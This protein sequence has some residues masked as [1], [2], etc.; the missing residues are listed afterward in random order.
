M[1]RSTLAGAAIGALALTACQTIGGSSQP[2]A[3]LT[4]DNNAVLAANLV[5]I[6]DLAQI[7]ADRTANPLNIP[8]DTAKWIGDQ[9]PLKAAWVKLVADLKAAGQTAPSKPSGLSVAPP[10]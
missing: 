8:S 9:T 6:G 10:T 2:N 1:K 5:V 3:T 4:A 7:N